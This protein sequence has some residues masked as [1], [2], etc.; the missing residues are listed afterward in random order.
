MSNSSASSATIVAIAVLENGR[1]CEGQG[2]ALIFDAQIYLG[3]DCPA[4]LAA[5]KYFNADNQAFDPVGFYIVIARVSVICFYVLSATLYTDSLARL[6]KWNQA[7]TLVSMTKTENHTMIWL[8][9]L[10]GYVSL[11]A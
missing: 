7:Q 5:L 4:L 10:L 11:I 6:P 2:R 3:D 8:V 9:M 1:F